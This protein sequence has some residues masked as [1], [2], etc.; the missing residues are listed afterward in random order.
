MG[1]PGNF[2]PETKYNRSTRVSEPDKNDPLAK[3]E[4]LQLIKL[5]WKLPNDTQREMVMKMIKTLAGVD[6]ETVE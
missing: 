2:P 3:N 1:L 5:Y 6:S 4:S